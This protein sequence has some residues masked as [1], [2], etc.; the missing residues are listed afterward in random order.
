MNIRKSI[1]VCALFS[2]NICAMQQLPDVEITDAQQ[3]QGISFLDLSDDMIRDVA[4]FLPSE[5][6]LR[7][8]S[9]CQRLERLFIDR[10]KPT[11]IAFSPITVQCSKC[12]WGCSD[13]KKCLTEMFNEI[14]KM[15]A[16]DHVSLMQLKFECNSFK[17]K[18]IP[19][20]DFIKRVY[21]SGYANCI[22][23]FTRYASHFLPKNIYLLRNLQRVSATNLTDNELLALAKV[24]SI[25]AIIAN[26]CICTYLPK[27]IEN[28]KKLEIFKMSLDFHLSYESLQNLALL[29]QLKNLEIKGNDSSNKIRYVLTQ[30]PSIFAGMQSLTEVNF[31]MNKLQACDLALIAAA[32]NLEKIIIWGNKI[33]HIPEEVGM[34]AKLKELDVQRNAIMHIP[35]C[36]AR[37]TNLQKLVLYDNPIKTVSHE[38][39][40][41]KQLQKVNIDSEVQSLFCNLW[42]Y[43]NGMKVFGISN[44]IFERP[45]QESVTSKSSVIVLPNNEM[46][47]SAPDSDDWYYESMLI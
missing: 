33:D 31:R 42:P 4:E 44:Y 47:L 20:E 40:H 45:R 17:D 12:G 2:L 11:E 26:N 37:C 35:A 30:L 5:D 16:N 43:L 25:R 27:S 14:T 6:V 46:L 7:L 38:L 9:V 1:L 28:L 18:I 13:F 36:L 24:S 29:K 23:E 15:A 8:S 3:T 19:R 32:K 34:L 21:Q 10:W 39:C 41:L 22:V